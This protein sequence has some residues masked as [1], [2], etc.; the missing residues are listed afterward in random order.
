MYMGYNC[1]YH[2]FN[3]QPP[4]GG[5]DD[6]RGIPTAMNVSTRS[7]PKAAGPLSGKILTGRQGF[8]TQP[9][10]GGWEKTNVTRVSII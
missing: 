10:E 7:R 3:T 5:W 6:G 4:E 1:I 8:N 2:S 9:P